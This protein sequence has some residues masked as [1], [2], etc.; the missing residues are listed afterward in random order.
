VSEESPDPLA[1]RVRN[2]DA[3]ALAEFLDARRATLL[4]FIE[5]KLGPALR[6]K[7]EPQDVLQEVA[8]KA[9]RELPEARPDDPFA[10]LCH[11]AGQCV[12]D[13]H[14]HFAAG[15]RAA[16]REVSGNVR[17]GDGSQDLIA[18]LR[19]SMTSPSQA[20]VRDERE[21]R[22]REAVASLPEEQREALRLRYGEGLPTK[23]VAR[24]LNKTDV[25]TRV[26]LTR[27]VQRLQEPL[28]P[29]ET[30]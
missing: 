13:G 8:V 19:A 14:R 20:A 11:L 29:G 6:G 3:A 18:L 17:A 28:G 22:L 4:A 27:L 7:L 23:E 25:A 2:G 30:S 5:R 10:W 1:E 12:I 26:L 24:R 9:L 16:G 15:K 21:E